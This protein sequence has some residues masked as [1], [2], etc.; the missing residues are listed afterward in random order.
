MTNGLHVVFYDPLAQQETLLRAAH[1]RL[2]KL[3]VAPRRKQGERADSRSTRAEAVHQVIG[4]LAVLAATRL[5][6]SCSE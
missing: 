3:A 6:T 5:A 4:D 1:I 2:P